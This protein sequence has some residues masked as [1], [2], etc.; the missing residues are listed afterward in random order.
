MSL[1]DPR[2][3]GVDPAYCD[4]LAASEDDFPEDIDRCP[5]CNRE[6]CMCDGLA[7]TVIPFTDDDIC[8]ECQ[9][10]PCLCEVLDPDEDHDDDD[11]GEDERDA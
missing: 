10:E 3:P 5:D 2:D 1:Y 8:P 4:G 9:H 11:A 6:P 7:A